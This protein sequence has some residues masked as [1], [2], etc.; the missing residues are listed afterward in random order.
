MGTKIAIAA[1]VHA[2]AGPSAAVRADRWAQERIIMSERKTYRRGWGI[3]RA[4][5]ARD[6][7]CD[8]SR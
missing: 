8:E 5:G 7:S 2:V 3:S 1:L 4:A 6:V